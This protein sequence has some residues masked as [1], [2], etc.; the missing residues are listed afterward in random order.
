MS[1]RYRS[2][3]HCSTISEPKNLKLRYWRS[4]LRKCPDIEDLSKS[5]NAPLILVYPG[6]DI[7]ILSFD[8]EESSISSRCSSISSKLLSG[9]Q[10]WNFTDFTPGSTVLTRIAVDYKSPAGTGCKSSNLLSIDSSSFACQFKPCPSVLPSPRCRLQN[11]VLSVTWSRQWE[12]ILWKKTYLLV[13][14]VSAGGG[15]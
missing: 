2:S 10:L 8:I 1:L 6:P 7:G 3:C 5:K 13:Q 14:N 9:W 4:K 11:I 12:I 15:H